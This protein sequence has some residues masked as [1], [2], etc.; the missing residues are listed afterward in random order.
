MTLSIGQL[1]SLLEENC[2]TSGCPRPIKSGICAIWAARLGV[3]KSHTAIFLL[4]E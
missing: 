2:I 1:T 3:I 4:A